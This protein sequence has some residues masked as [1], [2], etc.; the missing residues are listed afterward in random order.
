[1][2][3]EFKDKQYHFI[4]AGGIGMSGLAKVLLKNGAKI[5]GSDQG[6]G[7]IISRLNKLGA[8]IRCGHMQE[9]IERLGDDIEAVVISAAIS[10]DNPELKYAR[11]KGLRVL[12]YSDKLGSLMDLYSGIAVAGTHGKSSTS[13]W[14]AY[15]LEKL[16]LSPNYIIGADIP[17]LEGSSGVGD[18]EMFVAEACEYDRSFIKLRPQI[19]AVLNVEEDHLDYYKDVDDIIGAFSEFLSGVKSGGVIVA[20]ADDANVDKLRNAY[21]TRLAEFGRKPEKWVTFGI[22]KAADYTA[23]DLRLD[24]GFHSFELCYGGYPVGRIK[25]STPGIH[26]VYNCLA[27]IA[28][29]SCAGVAT[30]KIIEVCG[31]FIGA[32]RRLMVKAEANGIKVLDDYAHHPTEIRVSL[33]AI[34]DRYPNAK[35]ICVFQ[36]H[37]YSRTRFLLDDF[38][39]SFKLADLTIVPEIFFV[40]DTIASRQEVNASILVERIKQAGSDAVFID[41][42]SKICD[43]LKDAANS[44]DVVVTMGA[45]DIWKVAD[46]YIQW[47]R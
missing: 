23:T 8:D 10:E 38:A 3:L 28:I 20:N 7:F 18:G 4:G 34:R 13:G 32:D 6:G 31:N 22:D 15:I 16:G 25:L 39:E 26:N 47:L 36:P 40:R 41:G 29:S 27:A 19:A 1:M 5:S 35:I 11:H 45:G 12:K 2:K 42:F 14:V 43:Y 21:E 17:Q 24:D 44:G 33:K 37:Q 30:E 9:W 46:E